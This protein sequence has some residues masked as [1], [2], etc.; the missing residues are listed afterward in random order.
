[1]HGNAGPHD[2]G[3]DLLVRIQHGTV[4]ARHYFVSHSVASL[5]VAVLDSRHGR[6]GHF[7]GAQCRGALVG[8]RYAKQQGRTTL[9]GRFGI[10]FHL[11]ARLEALFL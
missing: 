5:D 2:G 9:V 7:G 8:S 10:A 6:V 4:L 11:F 3:L 1:M